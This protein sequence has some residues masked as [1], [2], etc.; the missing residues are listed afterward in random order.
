MEV[1]FQDRERLGE[2]Q[3]VHCPTCNKSYL[4]Y[5]Q[6]LH[7]ES[8]RFVCK[9][10]TQEFWLR[11]SDF[12]STALGEIPANTS[13]Q[14]LG[15]LPKEKCPKCGEGVDSLDKACE[16]CGVIG[17]KY[18]ALK[19]PSPYLKVNPE[20]KNLW[21]R[22]LNHLEDDQIHNEFI[23]QCLKEKQLRYSAQQYKQL[24]EAI[25]PDERVMEAI[26]KIQ[27][28]AELY[29]TEGRTQPVRRA[30][31]AKSSSTSRIYRSFLRWEAGLVGAGALCIVSGLASPMAR[32]L[33]GLGVVFL[34]LPL[35]INLFFRERN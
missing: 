20:L 28:L 22:V 21:Q 1:D 34:A 31:G 17:T 12:L 10:C 24:K 32:N 15:N 5:L 26:D 4:I 8:N 7:D 13:D 11:R 16:A 23:S 18:L 29:M 2:S 30:T 6:D 27:N 3:T 33:I 19:E 35:L 25:G 14:Y 9:A